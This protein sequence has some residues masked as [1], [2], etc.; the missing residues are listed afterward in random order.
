MVVAVPYGLDW[1]DLRIETARAAAQSGAAAALRTPVKV[2]LWAEYLRVRVRL[3]GGQP[4]TV[5]PATVGQSSVA[6][7]TPSLSP[8]VSQASPIP[9]PSPSACPG[10]AISWQLSEP[11]S[12]PSSSSSASQ[13]SPSPSASW[14]AWA[15]F[16]VV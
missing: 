1:P 4:L 9:S 12:K 3:T 8:S 14:F 6:S 7:G 16:D 10:L 5:A 11:S 2:R 13:A 15:G